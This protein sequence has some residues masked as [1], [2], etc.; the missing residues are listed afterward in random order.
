MA[1]KKKRL[2]ERIR[3]EALRENVAL[4]GDKSNG[5]VL[6]RKE[7]KNIENFD[8]QPFYHKHIVSLSENP[9]SIKTFV[10]FDPDVRTTGGW[11]SIKYIPFNSKWRVPSR[12]YV[13]G[14]DLVRLRVTVS[15]PK[16]WHCLCKQIPELGWLDR[17]GTLSDYMFGIAKAHPGMG[18][19]FTVDWEKYDKMIRRKAK[20]R[21]IDIDNHPFVTYMTTEDEL[22]EL[23]STYLLAPERGREEYEDIV[24][25]S[26][27]NY[28]KLE[29]DVNNG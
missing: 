11:Y 27:D 16:H 2:I 10:N 29:E 5:H 22:A 28:G 19:Y 14:Q 21:N 1:I 6:G 12:P 4:K 15:G 18:F 25:E 24:R 3:Q 8:F 7:V 23:N 26:N 9:V 20:E 17:N 13:I